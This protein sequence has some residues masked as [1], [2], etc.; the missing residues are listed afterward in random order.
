MIGAANSEKDSAM[1]IPDFQSIF[2]PLLKFMSD[3]KEHSVQEAV[4]ILADRYELSEEERGELL[5]SGKQAT[6]Y[7]RVS[8]A[9]TYLNKSGLIEMPRRS[10]YR[11]TDRGRSVLVQNPPRIDMK[12][13]QQFPE[14]IEFKSSKRKIPRT[15][16]IKIEPNV[17]TPEEILEDAYE[18]IRENLI[19]EIIDHVKNCS[20]AFFERLVIDLLV[21]MG[22][23]GSRLDAAQAIGQ[24]GDGGIDGIID[25]DR[26]GLD[27]IYIQAKKWENPVGR[28]EIQK[29]VGALMGEKAKKGIF[30]T[31]SKFSSE[32]FNYVSNI[33]YKIVLIDGQRLA[34][35]MIDFDLGVTEVISYRLKRIDSDYFNN[36]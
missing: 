7:N 12:F 36:G 14:Y 21:K 11:I 31:N 13:L 10:Y 27:T 29:F 15:K 2:L 1:P 5:P 25:E 16:P 35:F 30:I 32:A 4:D 28:P 34:E 19:Q 22:Y 17:R 6:F 23:G 8:W 26:L 24:S 3:G 9:R 20:P 33:D 18:E